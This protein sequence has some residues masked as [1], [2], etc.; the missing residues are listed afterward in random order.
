MAG[1]CFF[2][3]NCTL[4]WKAAGSALVC[5]KEQDVQLQPVPLCCQQASNL[6]SVLPTILCSRECPRHL[7]KMEKGR[8]FDKEQAKNVFCT[9]SMLYLKKTKKTSK[10]RQR[11]QTPDKNRTIQMIFL[12]YII[13][14]F[15]K[16]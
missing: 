4:L 10:I 13:L 1:Q 14:C 12:D 11:T 15:A 5:Q 8:I 9:L 2:S 6:S 7:K 16:D 3:P